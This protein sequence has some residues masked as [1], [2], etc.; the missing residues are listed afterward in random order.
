[1]RELG[2]TIS[3]DF[4]AAVESSS[5]EIVQVAQ[6]PL[7]RAEASYLYQPEVLAVSVMDDDDDFVI[8]HSYPFNDV[9]V[10]V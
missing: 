8:H 6:K 5:R 4:V 3:P 2:E 9:G 7:R 1:M 10:G